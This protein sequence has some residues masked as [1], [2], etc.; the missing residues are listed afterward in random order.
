MCFLGRTLRH[1]LF[2]IC[3]CCSVS[4]SSWAQDSGKE[5]T[6]YFRGETLKADDF[7]QDQQYRNKTLRGEEKPG[8]EYHIDRPG[9]DYHSFELLEPLPEICL[10]KCLKD[11]RCLAYTYVKP[12]FQGGKARCFL[13]SEVRNPVPNTCC[14]S[15]VKKTVGEK[16]QKAEISIQKKAES[17]TSPG[18]AKSTPARSAPSEAPVGKVH[19]LHPDLTVTDFRFEVL[20]WGPIYAGHK[21][22]ERWGKIRVKGAMKNIGDHFDFPNFGGNIVL[23]GLPV[24]INANVFGYGEPPAQFIIKTQKFGK[25]LKEQIVGFSDEPIQILCKDTRN[26]YLKIVYDHI[27]PV[28]GSKM[29]IDRNWQNNQRTLSASE[30]QKEF[31][32]R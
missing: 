5:G 4:L 12:G 22:E 18:L 32:Y 9:G 21:P 29:D 14:V 11:E 7:E 15:G 20:G 26:L 8:M 30:F 6:R 16:Q 3:L 17:Q 10:E 28:T 13:K 1:V 23:Y 25:V 27:L 31:C 2:V 24:Q 19:L